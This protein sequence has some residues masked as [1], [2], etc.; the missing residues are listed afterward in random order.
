MFSEGSH[1]KWTGQTEK[2]LTLSLRA[3]RY[4]YCGYTV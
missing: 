2:I 4:L 3:N 1:E